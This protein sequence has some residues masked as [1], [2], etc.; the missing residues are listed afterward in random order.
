L[1]NFP[2]RLYD[3]M[4]NRRPVHPRLF[5]VTNGFDTLSKEEREKTASRIFSKN[6][7][8]R[9]PHVHRR[10]TKGSVRSR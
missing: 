8:C 2:D 7:D 3:R 6:R 1:M 9:P 4:A 10:R 5:I